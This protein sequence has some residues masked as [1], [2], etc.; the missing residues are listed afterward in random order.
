MFCMPVDLPLEL[1]PLVDRTHPHDHVDDVIPFFACF[2]VDIYRLAV[3]KKLSRA[4]AMTAGDG[5][6]KSMQRAAAAAGLEWEAG[7]GQ[8]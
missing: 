8:G 3:A 7:A 1:W 2:L 4:A 5:E 6:E